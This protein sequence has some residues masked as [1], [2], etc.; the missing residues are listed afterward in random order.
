MPEKLKSRKFWLAV[1]TAAGVAVAAQFG[2][3]PELAAKIVAGLV[4]AFI[5][6]EGLTD[7]ARALEG[8]ENRK[9]K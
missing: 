5:G 9:D 7:A 1:L 6:A 8:N 4:A 2:L 3:D